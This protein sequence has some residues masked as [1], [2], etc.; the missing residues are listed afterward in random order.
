MH[1]K[2]KPAAIKHV[3]LILQFIKELVEYKKLL[4]EVVSTEDILLEKLF[5]EKS[6]AEV[7]I[8]YHDSKPFNF[9]LFFHN[10]P[11]FLGRPGI[12]LEDLYV[13]S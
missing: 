2:I 10:F 4:S 7:V 13:K 8:G 12:Y 5:G 11:F 6:N 9:A 1:S 3:T